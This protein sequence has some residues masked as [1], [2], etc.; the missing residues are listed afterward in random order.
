MLKPDTGRH[1]FCDESGPDPQAA[2]SGIHGVK[3]LILRSNPQ[4]PA[5]ARWVNLSP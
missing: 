3:L 4:R 2:Q 5:E 1:A